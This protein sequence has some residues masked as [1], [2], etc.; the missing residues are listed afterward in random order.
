MIEGSDRNLR[1]AL[2]ILRTAHWFEHLLFTGSAR[3][4]YALGKLIQPD[5]YR[6]NQNADRFNH[7]LWPK[8]AVGKHVPSAAV[9]DRAEA[10]V[11]DSRS[12]FDHV[13]FDALDPTQNIGTRGNALIRR[14]HPGVQHAIF[15][16]RPLMR[17][18]FRRRSSWRRAA[19]A[20][21]AIGDLD[22]VAA[23]VVMVREAAESNDP[24]RAHALGELLQRAFLIA[25][26]QIIAIVTGYELGI[27]LEFWV[28]R[29]TTYRGLRYRIDFIE[30]A[31]AAFH[32]RG[33]IG[34]L[35]DAAEIGPLEEDHA[36]TAHLILSGRWNEVLHFALA[37]VPVIESECV[38][39]PLESRIK[40]RQWEIRREWA[41]ATLRSGKRAPFLPIELIN[42]L[43][44]AERILKADAAASHQRSDIKP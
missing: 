31:K 35:D 28:M 5:T 24:K 15:E 6:K 41:W 44:E 21:A 29:L 26:L 33:V 36:R 37:P 39:V 9:L 8:Y 32:L 23:L 7:N 20:V 42:R 2:D 43:R 17:G 22:A 13:L 16:A 11:Q 12:A 25:S 27:A 10:V 30:D 1:R 3:T 34:G 40:A 19:S 38:D 4:A 18:T 14:T